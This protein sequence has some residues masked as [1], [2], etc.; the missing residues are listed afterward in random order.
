MLTL[1]IWWLQIPPLIVFVVDFCSIFP[2]LQSQNK[3]YAQNANVVSTLGY[4][5]TFFA[6][7]YNKRLLQLCTF[8]L[9]CFHGYQTQSNFFFR[10]HFPYFSQFPTA[11]ICLFFCLREVWCEKV[12]SPYHA[13]FWGRVKFWYSGGSHKLLQIF[14][15]VLFGS[16]QR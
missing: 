11:R 6:V 16:L 13:W 7:C 2:N 1:Q 9:S 4:R 14:P 10:W 8:R 5:G 15:Q 12:V 3:N